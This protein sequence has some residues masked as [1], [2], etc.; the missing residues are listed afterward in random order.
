MIA[1]EQAAGLTTSSG[2]RFV[3]N[4]GA[5]VFAFKGDDLYAHDTSPQH[6][7]PGQQGAVASPGA[8]E[9][10]PLP[11][12]IRHAPCAQ[13]AQQ[14]QPQLSSSQL[15]RAKQLARQQLA[16]R[17]AGPP[18]HEPRLNRGKTDRLPPR[19]LGS[20]HRSQ[21]PW[22][23]RA[24]APG[25]A[26][27]SS[28]ADVVI[29]GGVVETA[30]YDE[31]YFRLTRRAIPPVRPS[32]GQGPGR[33]RGSPPQGVWQTPRPPEGPMQRGCNGDGVD[34]DGAAAAAAAAA[35]PTLAACHSERL[36]LAQSIM[37]GEGLTVACKNTFLEV[38]GEPDVAVGVRPQSSPPVLVRFRLDRL[39][40]EPF[41][42]EPEVPTMEACELPAKNELRAQTVDPILPGAATKLVL[43]Q[44]RQCG[45]QKTLDK[46]QDTVQP[47]REPQGD[48]ELDCRRDEKLDPTGEAAAKR[49]PPCPSKECPLTAATANGGMGREPLAGAAEPADREGHAGEVCLL[50]AFEGGPL[51]CEERRAQSDFLGFPSALAKAAQLQARSS[52]VD[53]YCSVTPQCYVQ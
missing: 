49:A 16:A 40:G 30:Q 20:Q 27:T 46:I 9:T 53:R 22:G 47:G 41:G 38:T 28:V 11:P 51:D 1:Q 35:R 32:A 50:S 2:T 23:R 17:P 37:V 44:D 10:A 48:P 29:R 43:A 4:T 18:V 24:P 6:P 39:G 15:E 36:R 21:Q 26:D 42:A 8:L 45:G 7:G 31:G 25:T 3:W 13:Q 52:C 19:R 5:P 12:H 14:V 33:S 34:S